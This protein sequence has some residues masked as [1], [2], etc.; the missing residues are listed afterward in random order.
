MWSELIE[1]Y[2]VESKHGEAMLVDSNPSGSVVMVD[3]EP[4]Y[5][6]DYLVE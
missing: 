2:D 3:D 1:G 4:V 5:T 6:I